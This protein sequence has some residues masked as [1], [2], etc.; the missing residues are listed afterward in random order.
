MAC[1]LFGGLSIDDPDFGDIFKKF[2]DSCLA[3]GTHPKVK[4]VSDKDLAL[5]CCDKATDPVGLE[6]AASGIQFE[7]VIP[8][9]LALDLFQG[10]PVPIAFGRGKLKLTYEAPEK[11]SVVCYYKGEQSSEGAIIKQDD[12]KCHRCLP[13]GTWG[14]G[15]ACE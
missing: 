7:L 11:S 3:G 4:W 5:Y 8:G 14:S 12:G 10:T 2:V 1:H 15:T 13:D 6:P 9:K